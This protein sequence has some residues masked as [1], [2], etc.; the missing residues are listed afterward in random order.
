MLAFFDNGDY[1]VRKRRATAWTVD[2]EPDARARDGRPG[3]QRKKHRRPRSPRSRASSD[4][5]TPA[6]DRAQ[7]AWEQAM[8]STAGA[9]RPLDAD[10][11]AADR[12]RGAEACDRRLGPGVGRQPGPRRPTPSSRRHAA[13]GITAFR[14]E[15][16]PDPSRRGGPGRDAYGNFVRHRLRG[17]RRRRRTA[18]SPHRAGSRAGA[19]EPIEVRRLSALDASKPDDGTPPD[20]FLPP[21]ARSTSTRR[22]RWGID[23]MPRAT[24]ACRVILLHRS[25]P[26]GAPAAHGSRITLE[27]SRA[28]RRNSPG[29]FRLSVT[30]SRMPVAR[31]RSRR[32]I[33]AILAIAAA[34]RTEQQ[35]RTSPP[36][37]AAVAP[38]LKP[39]ATVAELQRRARRSPSS[40]FPRARHAERAGVERPSTHC[41]AC[42][43][44]SPPGERVYAAVPGALPP[45]PDDQMPN[46][47][48]LAH[49]LVDEENPLT[50]RV[51]VNRSGSSSSAAA[52][53]RPARTSAR[54]ASRRRIPSCS[55][56][57]PPSSSRKAGA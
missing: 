41:C 52:S 32:R 54:R 26:V 15:A 7:A 17:R 47:L 13:A 29:R 42:A 40:R 19:L 21:G 37:S 35:P 30:S 28:P 56:G 45:L 14:L 11:R 53:W 57:W 2:V 38:S 20:A 46:R 16:L 23:A 8:R 18:R 55:T 44:L 31:R 3:A 22:R 39:R 25:A 34:D 27:H 33:R 36:T 48:G 50:A 49:W 12:R 5:T 10:V 6:L 4:A 24:R 1:R 43:A 51:T 9:G